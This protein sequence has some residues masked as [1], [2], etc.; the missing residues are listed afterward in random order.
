MGGRDAALGIR[1][2]FTSTG[3]GDMERLGSID[4]GAEFLGGPFPLVMLEA[5]GVEYVRAR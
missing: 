5:Y 2:G 3:R 1:V 4:F